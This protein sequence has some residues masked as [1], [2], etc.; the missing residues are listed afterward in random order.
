MLEK[1]NKQEDLDSQEDK[2]LPGTLFESDEKTHV[3]VNFHQ[4][5][6]HQ[7]RNSLSI[8]IP[9]SLV[10]VQFD[11]GQ[12]EYTFLEFFSFIFISKDHFDIQ[13]YLN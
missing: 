4:H 7:R 12:F 6:S 8:H 11:F 10:E 2:E 1:M 13:H 5:V 3:Q 9:P